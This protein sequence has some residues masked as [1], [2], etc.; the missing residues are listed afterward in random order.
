MAQTLTPRQQAYREYLRGPRWRFV[1]WVR[2]VLD[3]GAC[4]DCL[5]V[6]RITRRGLQVHHL[7][8]RHKGGSITG[9]IGDTV[10]LCA[11]CHAKRHGKT[12]AN[13]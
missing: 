11:D 2:K 6:G 7:D 1:R 3:L 9:E 12:V 4:Q 10:T 8:Y 13:D 5:K